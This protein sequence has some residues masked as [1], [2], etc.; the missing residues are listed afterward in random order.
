[1]VSVAPTVDT[2]YDVLALHE[3][4]PPA[5]HARLE[6]QMRATLHLTALLIAGTAMAAPN[7]KW[8]GIPLSF[9]PNRGQAAG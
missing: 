9:E 2:G 5:R 6:G 3:R 8:S 4:G 7:F 1:M